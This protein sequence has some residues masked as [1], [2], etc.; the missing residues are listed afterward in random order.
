MRY[1][2]AACDPRRMAQ[3]KLYKLVRSLPNRIFKTKFAG[4]PSDAPSNMDHGF[5][6]REVD[7]SE[8]RKFVL[9]TAQGHDQTVIG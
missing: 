2:T 3:H 8:L 1:S 9:P 4:L 7:L 5:S 6:L